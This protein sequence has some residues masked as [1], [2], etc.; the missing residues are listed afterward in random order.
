MSL[1]LSL[2]LKLGGSSA[3]GSAPSP[4]AGASAS[5]FAIAPSVQYHP[6]T[7]TMTMRAV[8]N[9]TGYISGNTMTIVTND[10]P[11]L[12][13]GDVVVGAAAGTTIL[14]CG[15]TFGATSGTFTVSVSQT[16]GSAGSPVAF[17]VD[18]KTVTAI[19]DLKGL[20]NL[21]SLDGY[22]PRL[23]TDALGRKFL[24][25]LM[26]ENYNGSWLR[27]L[28]LGALDTYNST[29]ILVGRFH[30]AWSNGTIISYGLKES[31]T[32]TSAAPLAYNSHFPVP[33][34]KSLMTNL[35]SGNVNKLLLGA[36]M[37]VLGLA[38]ATNLAVGVTTSTVGCQLMLNE[39]VASITMSSSQATGKTGFE[40]GK[41]STQA[42]QNNLAQ[43]AIFDLYELSGWLKGEMGNIA[44]MTG[45]ASAQQATAVSNYNI[46]AVTDSII[47]VGDSRSINGS[48]SGQ[49][50]GIRMTDPGYAFAIPATTRVLNT[51]VS[52]AGIG[53]MWQNFYKVHDTHNTG[54]S[55]PLNSSLMLGSGHDTVGIFV[56][57]NDTASRWPQSSNG[58]RGGASQSVGVADDYYNG[59]DYTNSFT[60][61]ITTATNNPMTVTGMTGWLY[62]GSKLT[63]AG[64]SA[65]LTCATTSQTGPFNINANETPGVTSVAGTAVLS[66]LQK[67]VQALLTQGYNV[68]WMAE[69]VYGGADTAARAELAVKIAGAQAD[70]AAVI[71]STLAANLKVG[72]FAQ[73]KLGGLYIYGANYTGSSAT[74]PNWLDTTHPSPAGMSVLVSGGD[75]VT[76]GYGYLLTH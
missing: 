24:R 18:T 16:L 74:D 27:N 4:P 52:G 45:N 64:T 36:Q 2:G 66:S 1:G 29:W 13:I 39:Q 47:L 43:Y 72:D 70:A 42:T 57:I 49:N 7:S 10:G 14:R 61:T 26:P 31:G 35:A 67:Y 50:I 68:R 17:T 21:T 63:I 46:P 20:A 23:M 11:P 6:N 54:Y 5:N 8:N 12:M 76:K 34:T 55:S 9:L 40:V 53:V 15:T 48:T 28:T 73:L 60:A 56:G 65:G 59:A 33:L 3:G 58:G 71:G 30:N 75:D 62:E 69:T 41:L 44:A 22:G 37:Q 25:F 51:A 19:N 38:T 32:G